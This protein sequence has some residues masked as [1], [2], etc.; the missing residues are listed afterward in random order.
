M[1]VVTT[2]VET[3]AVKLVTKMLEMNVQ[4]D[5]YVSPQMTVFHFGNGKT[6]HYFNN[7]AL[8]VQYPS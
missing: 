8:Q 1:M 3:E 6:G 7:F 2:G 4:R 5:E